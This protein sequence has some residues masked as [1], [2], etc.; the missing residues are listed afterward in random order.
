MQCSAIVIFMHASTVHAKA[1]LFFLLYVA[2]AD[3]IK[4]LNISS[5]NKYSGKIPGVILAA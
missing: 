5:Y 4:M 3:S 1:V 2:L